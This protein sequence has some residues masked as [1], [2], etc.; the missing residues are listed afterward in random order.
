MFEHFPDF[1]DTRAAREK[2]MMY[3][4]D[5]VASASSNL[6]AIELYHSSK[7]PPVPRLLTFREY[8]FLKRLARIFEVYLITAYARGDWSPPEAEEYFIDHFEWLL[9]TR[10]ASPLGNKELE[11]LEQRLLRREKG[12]FTYV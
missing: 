5:L 9:D 10:F 6:E 1:K 2:F 4:S 11:D 7:I 3:M 12:R 8:L